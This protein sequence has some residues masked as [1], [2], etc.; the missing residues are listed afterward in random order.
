MRASPSDLTSSISPITSY[1]SSNGGVTRTPNSDGGRENET[2]TPISSSRKK[3]TVFDRLTDQSSFTGI[4]KSSKSRGKD[5]SG[6]QR[7]KGRSKHV[8]TTHQLSSPVMTSPRENIKSENIEPLPSRETSTSDQAPQMTRR[9]RSSSVND[10]KNAP[11]SSSSQVTP[12]SSRQDV[13]SRLTDKSLYT[14]MYRFRAQQSPRGSG[15]GSLSEHGGKRGSF[16]KST[17]STANS[18]NTGNGSNPPSA[19]YE[20]FILVSFRIDNTSG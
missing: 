4:F 20:R 10:E 14:G 12:N 2:A 3:L 8:R 6:K 9:R 7:E 18:G 17:N 19:R 1:P 15:R 13:F 5:R 11:V 16:V